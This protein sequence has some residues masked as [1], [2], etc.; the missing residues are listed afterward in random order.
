[1]EHFY[2]LGLTAFNEDRKMIEAQQ[3]NINS[4]NGDAM[5]T[6]VSDSALSQFR[7]MMK[8]ILADE[9]RGNVGESIHGHE[10]RA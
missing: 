9:A 2:Q 1:M 10:A 4:S 5:L 6:T 3:R 7:R 8:K